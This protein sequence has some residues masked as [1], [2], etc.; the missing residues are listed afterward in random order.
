[1]PSTSRR[2][3]SK[4]TCFLDTFQEHGHA[5]AMFPIRQYAQPDRR[6]RPSRRNLAETHDEVGFAES[7]KLEQAIKANLRRLVYGE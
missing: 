7:A 6:T 4:R 5:V 3:M 1:M 2:D